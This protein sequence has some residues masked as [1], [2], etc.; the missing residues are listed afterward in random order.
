[1]LEDVTVLDLVK[2]KVERVGLEVFTN[3]DP[4]VEGFEMLALGSSH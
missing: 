1:M 4:E 2:N 3:F